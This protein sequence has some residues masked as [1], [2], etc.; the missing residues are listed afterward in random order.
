VLP[1]SRLLARA[2]FAL[3]L[4]LVSAV[5]LA[6]EAKDYRRTPVP[7]WVDWVA[8]PTPPS[9]PAG[10]DRIALL[11]D[12]QISLLGSE[13]QRFYRRTSWVA[14]A[15]GIARAGDFSIDFDPAFSQV[16]IHGIWVERKGERSDRLASA[17]IDT[18]RRES[19]LE[20]GLLDGQLTLHLVLDDIRVGDIVDFAASVTGDNPALDGI[21]RQHYWFSPD[22]P[23]RL[24][25]VRILRPATRT[26]SVKASGDAI[27]HRVVELGAQT[28]ERWLV[29]DLAPRAGEDRVPPWHFSGPELEIADPKTWQ[30]VVQWALPLYALQDAS[31]VD[32]LAAELGLRKGSGDEAGVLEAIRF[33]QEEIRYTG[34]ELGAHAYRPYPAGTVLQRR[35]GDCKDK[36]SLLVSL[37]RHQ[38]VEAHAAFVDVDDRARIDARLPGP[39]AFDHVIV[40]FE[41]DGDEYWV[42]ATAEHQR[43]ELA[44]RVA[45]PF[46]RALLI[47][48]GE[49]ALRDIPPTRL[50]EPRVDIRETIDLRDGKGGLASDGDYRITTIYRGASAENQRRSFAND[51]VAVIGQGYV[52]AVAVY[53][54][55]VR[56]ASEP[57]ASDDPKTNEFTVEEHYTLVDLWEDR[58]D[59]KPG[60]QADFWLSEIDRA[61]ALPKAV[62]RRD[63]WHLGDHTDVRQRLEIL[64]DGGWPKEHDDLSIKNPYF[65]FE[66][67]ASNDGERFTLEGRLRTHATEVPAADVATLRRDIVQ[68]SDDVSYALLLGEDDAELPDF[69]SW[70]DWRSLVVLLGTL[71]LWGWIIF[72]AVA[73]GVSPAIG[74]WFRPRASIRAGIEANRQTLAFG[75]IALSTGLSAVLDESILGA[76]N[77]NRI[78]YTLFLLAAMTVGTLIGGAIS[79]V[80]Y[81]WFG[82]LL[83]GQG[84]SDDLLIVTGFVQ[85]PMLAALPVLVLA[86][87]LFGPNLVLA[88]EGPM[89]FPLILIGLLVLVPM[90]LWSVIVWI[91]SLAEAHRIGL[92]RALLVAVLP[93]VVLGALIVAVVLALQ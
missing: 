71:L 81:A 61:L 57:V 16:Q 54:P 77:E 49:S 46:R 1:A 63:P 30:D 86:L 65:T 34:L 74:M 69:A 27:D 15:S 32:A 2:A 20:S 60:S 25:Q 56:Q 45:P 93:L 35:Y 52:E 79:A 37:L 39:Q 66:G 88:P 8:L 17:R 44:N 68:L 5:A 47:A 59:E 38:G 6:A 78:G 75:L 76:V 41:F 92:G 82:R 26:L 91:P 3:S 80:I 22:V 19:G 43:G 67:V 62:E 4:L 48:P 64:L 23:T 24:R 42:D 21:F 18:L 36:A 40:R 50:E 10:G 14:S 12:D 73:R 89:I 28:D 70:F 13:S 83:G 29:Q 84:R 33:V 53:Y 55:N 7:E 87:A 9:G 11:A 85:V 72:C 31:T 58:A 90:I 51:S